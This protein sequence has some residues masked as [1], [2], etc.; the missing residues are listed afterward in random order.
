MIWMKNLL[1]LIMVPHQTI[2][3]PY[4]SL[5]STLLL[6][7]II[8]STLATFLSLVCSTCLP[9]SPCLFLSSVCSGISC[10]QY[11]ALCLLKS[12][13]VPIL[14]Y[15]SHTNTCACAWVSLQTQS[16]PHLLVHSSPN[17]KTWALLKKKPRKVAVET[18]RA[19]IFQM[20]ART[21]ARANDCS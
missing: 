16:V 9:Q 21:H 14:H 12:V 1:N 13:H 5:C 17:E 6:F 7:F 15:C 8:Y 19:V 2:F 4:L 18:D 20:H 10:I 3:T 11:F